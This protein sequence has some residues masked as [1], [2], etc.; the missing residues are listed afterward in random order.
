VATV[1][2]RVRH[3]VQCTFGGRRI[4][5]FSGGPAEATETLLEEIRG[6]H[7]GGGFGSIVG[8]NSF[9]RKKADALKL[10]GDIIDIYSEK[11]S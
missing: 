7:Q 11:N 5:I 1:A 9:Q 10:L 6:I 3:I 4:V 8:R 2:G